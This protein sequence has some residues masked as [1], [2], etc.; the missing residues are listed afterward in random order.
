[1]IHKL[2][3]IVNTNNAATLIGSLEAT[4]LL[5]NIVFKTLNSCSF[6]VDI[7]NDI[8]RSN[9]IFKLNENGANIGIMQK[10]GNSEL[11]RLQ[12]FDTKP[13]T[14]I[15]FFKTNDKITKPITIATEEQQIQRRNSQQVLNPA[16][17]K[18]IKYK[19]KYLTLKNE[20]IAKGL[21]KKN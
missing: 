11:G 8:F 14:N 20:M 21:I 3:N 17:E 19:N 18:Y 2:I 4:N 16:A 15:D 10:Q 6:N 9:K 1:M 13:W 12:I 5:Q 7:Y